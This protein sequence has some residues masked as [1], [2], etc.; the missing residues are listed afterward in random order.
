VE[1]AAWQAA[2]VAA[3]ARTSLDEEAS[4][5][6]GRAH[7]AQRR[8]AQAVPHRRRADATS[9]TPRRPRFAMR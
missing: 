2:S 6:T 9:A 7:R 4:A 3:A 8:L 5:A 1:Q